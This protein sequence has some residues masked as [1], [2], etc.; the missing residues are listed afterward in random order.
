MK[1]IVVDP[2]KPLI[3]VLIESNTFLFKH[4]IEQ[5]CQGT[6]LIADHNDNGEVVM[7]A[8]QETIATFKKKHK[9]NIDSKNSFLKRLLKKVV[10]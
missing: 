8:L 10:R 4:D 6:V 9:I 5:F 2:D 7:S 3:V 1:K